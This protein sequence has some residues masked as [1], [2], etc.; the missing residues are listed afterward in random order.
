MVGVHLLRSRPTVNIL[1]HLLQEFHHLGGREVVA[2][3]P[4]QI[5]YI[6]VLLATVHLLL[7]WRDSVDQPVGGYTNPN[8]A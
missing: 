4:S 6:V 2:R 8:K 1:E 5:F 7:Q 3:F